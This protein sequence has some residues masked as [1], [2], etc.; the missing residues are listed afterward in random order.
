MSNLILKLE[1]ITLILNYIKSNYDNTQI[2]FSIDDEVWCN[3]YLTKIS[4]II[5]YR[6][7]LTFNNHDRRYVYVYYHLF[8]IYKKQTILD[9]ILFKDQINLIPNI[10]Y[11]A[12]EH[13]FRTELENKII[14]YFENILS[15]NR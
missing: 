11:A 12:G 2:E 8:P 1:L 10:P 4:K 7:Y 14:D 6:K 5:D 3:N 13:I 9:K 15:I